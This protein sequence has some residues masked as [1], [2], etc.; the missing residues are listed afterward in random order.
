MYHRMK[1]FFYVLLRETSSQQAPKCAGKPSSGS[2]LVFLCQDQVPV[3]GR[4]SP[5]FSA[6][7]PLRRH[8]GSRISDGGVFVH[9][10]VPSAS[11]LV[12]YVVLRVPGIC[13]SILYDHWYPLQ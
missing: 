12:E 8:G 2:A 7:K 10:E 13:V 6:H 3:M 9:Y 1:G 5:L 11:L 4:A